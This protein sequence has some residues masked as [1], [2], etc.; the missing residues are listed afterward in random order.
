MPPS[1]AL[2]TLVHGVI[3]RLSERRTMNPER[4]DDLARALAASTSRRGALKVLA[5]A[6]IGGFS[7]AFAGSRGRASAQIG[8]QT[9]MK[10]TNASGSDVRAY[11]TLGIPPGCVSSVAALPFVT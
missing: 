9:A 1:V 8:S 3:R 7:A 4:F 2:A 10:V 5:G 11:I 6:A